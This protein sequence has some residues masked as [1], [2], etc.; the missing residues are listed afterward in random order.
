MK[1]LR[2]Y[3]LVMPALLLSLSIIA[4]PGLLTV[5]VSFTDWNGVSPHMNWIGLG[6]YRSIVDDKVFWQA[7]TN[8]F[9]WTL[10]F[11]TIPVFI[12]LLTA[13]LLLRRK[14]GR[15]AYQIIFLFP[16]VL[17]PVTN[18]I[19]WLNIM[20]NPLTGWWVTCAITAS[21]CAR[22]W[23]TSTPRCTRSPRSISGTTGAF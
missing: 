21:R 18:A 8:N 10:L 2:Y 5:Y 4:V 16:Y 14:H 7:P 11:L 6:N 1:S 19:L 20:L 13:M 17:A 3:L 15:T 22:R 23:V 12:G 9:R